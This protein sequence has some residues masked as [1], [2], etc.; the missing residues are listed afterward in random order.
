MTKFF[1]SASDRNCL[2]CTLHRFRFYNE[3]KCNVVSFEF[4]INE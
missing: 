4:R 2:S 3:I 1:V